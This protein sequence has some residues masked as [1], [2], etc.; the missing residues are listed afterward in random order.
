MNKYE[1]LGGTLALLALCN[2]NSWNKL[3][4]TNKFDEVSQ[5]QK[6]ATELSY[7][8]LFLCDYF[9]S[10]LAEN[11]E[12]KSNILD[13]FY[14]VTFDFFDKL[15]NDEETY[16]IKC[17][18][19]DFKDRLII[20]SNLFN[21]TDISKSAKLKNCESLIRELSEINWSD[22]EVQDFYVSFWAPEFISF[23]QTIEK[24]YK[25]TRSN[26]FVPIILIV[27]II[28]VIAYFFF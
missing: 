23:V 25:D 11:N 8:K 22:D 21:K 15:N 3:I 16:Y 17:N 4:K 20:Y 13:K 1:K 2:D 26:S 12:I 10:M 7:C 18:E 6:Y 24:M 9:I 27:I 5:F 19:Q 28:A 14:E